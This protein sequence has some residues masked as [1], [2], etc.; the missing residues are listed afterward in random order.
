MNV[1][2]IW[3]IAPEIARQLAIPLLILAVVFDRARERGRVPNISE[4]VINGIVFLVPIGVL[5]YSLFYSDG[6]GDI[7]YSL[8]V[9]GMWLTT[10]YVVAN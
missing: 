8:V 6:A 7:L 9:V 1:S 2:D 3:R 5:N 10:L 4:A